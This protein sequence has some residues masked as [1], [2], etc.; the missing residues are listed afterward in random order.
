MMVMK[1]WKKALIGS[2]AAMT[3]GGLVSSAVAADKSFSPF[4]RVA[5]LDAV[6]VDGEIDEVAT[7]K[8]GKAVADAIARYID[9]NNEAET[10]GL[11][12]NWILAG[13]DKDPLS[14][15]VAAAILNVPSKLRIDSSIPMSSTNNRKIAIVEICNKAYASKALGV[16]DIIEGVKIPNGFIH[17]PA[18]PCEI[19]VHN[20]GDKI[21]VN[22]LDAQAIFTLFFTDVVTSELMLDPDFAEQMNMLP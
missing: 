7:Y 18:L 3:L 19:S 4:L 13:A 17:A 2:V 5:T 1:I 21:H 20:E 14:D 9:Q 8:K 15:D 16:V 11:P 12:S 6:T 22:M 10:L